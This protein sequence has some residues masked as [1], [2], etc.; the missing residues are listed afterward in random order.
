MHDWLVRFLSKIALPS[1]TELLH[2]VLLELLLGGTDLDARFDTIG[3]QWAGAIDVPLLKDLLLGLR[4]PTKEV[5][6][7]LGSRLG[8]INGE[9]KVVVLE[10]ETDTGKVDF[11]LD[12]DLLELLG[13]TDTRTL[14][15]KWS[16]ERSAGD[17][18]LLAGSDLAPTVLLA[19]SERLHW[20]DLHGGGSVTLQDDFVDLSV[21]H[22]V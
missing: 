22:E 18:N 3:S 16:A 11:G 7:A 2:V 15:H 14:E 19:G 10:V 21:A 1:W 9:S 20:A 8:T 13:I 17:H 4:V 12:T 5:V 6:K